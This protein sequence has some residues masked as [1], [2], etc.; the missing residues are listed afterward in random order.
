MAQEGNQ[1]RLLGMPCWLVQASLV[2]V[3]LAAGCISLVE[4]NSSP[5]R[6]VSW[7]P[8]P[9][10]AKWSTQFA[11]NSILA[12]P[13]RFE[14]TGKGPE[15]I[16]VNPLNGDVATGFDD[17]TIHLISG[18]SGSSKIVANTKGVPLGLGFLPD[19]SLIVADSMRGLLHVELSGNVTVLSTESEG[20][21]LRYPDG[22]VVDATGRNVYFTDVST[23]YGPGADLLEIIEHSGTGRLLR[24][25][26]VTQR[27]TTLL[28][29][30]Q[31]ANGV[32][33]GPG[34]AYVV[35]AETGSNRI[36]QYWLS[37]PMAGHSRVFADGLPGFPDN[38]TFNGRDKFWVAIVAP[39]ID[40]LDELA[41]APALRRLLT[42]FLIAHI[43][44]LPPQP[45]V[46]A[47]DLSGNP[48]ASLKGRGPHVFAPIT[49]AHEVG[50]RL[51]LGSDEAPCLAFVPRPDVL[52]DPPSS[53][54][55]RWP[56][57]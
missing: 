20:I 8:A 25:D 13:T 2:L 55:A 43:A 54:S 10:L 29:G 39:R 22:L 5:T 27:T 49:E 35:V 45:A 53:R 31:F 57:N 15:S 48:V 16:A 17:G 36:Q 1:A 33:L 3:G 32:A 23:R 4:F 41:G 28:S 19:S 34:D 51:I 6:P 42:P 26:T 7:R 24:Y 14:C 11:P 12:N 37:G 46:V 56:R 9:A 18:G 50:S 21:P 40:L 52:P 47:L 44:A 38:I 30:L